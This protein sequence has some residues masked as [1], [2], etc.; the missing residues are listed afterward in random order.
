M[1]G[2]H[3]STFI[4]TR[5]GRGPSGRW[6]THPIATTD[7]FQATSRLYVDPSIIAKAEEDHFSLAFARIEC[8]YF[9]YAGFFKSTLDFNLAH[10]VIPADGQLLENASKLKD[11]PMTIVQGRYDMV[12]PATT[13]W[14]VFRN[15]CLFS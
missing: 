11:I 2:K 4:L 5:A 13:A 1:P 7:T 12:C 10:S 9:V 3:P 15:T 6:H 14:W 8:H